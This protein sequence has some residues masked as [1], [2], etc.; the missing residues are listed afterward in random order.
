MIDLNVSINLPVLWGD[1]T[2]EKNKWSAINLFVGPNGTGKTLF[3]EEL[4]KPLKANGYNPRP[5]S[6]ER[7]FGLEKQDYVHFGSRRHGDSGINIA[8]FDR[9]KSEGASFGLVKDAF[10]L[11]KERLDLRITIETIL[12]DIFKKRMRLSEQ[13]GFLKPKMQNLKGGEE[14]VL[15]DSECHGLKELIT[16]LTFIYDKTFDTLI[17]D[18][19]ELHLHPQ[20]Q[21]FLLEEIRKV[22]G[23]PKEDNEKKLFFIISH[24][25]YFLE[26]RTVDDLKNVL[27]FKQENIPTYI[28]T[29]R[30]EDERRLKKFLPRFNTH[31][32]QFFFSPNPVFVEGYTDQQIISLL[33]DK[34]SKNIG[35]S[36]SCVIDVGG[37]DEL[38][39]F[40][41]LCEILNINATFVADLDALFRGRLR[42]TVCSNNKANQYIQDCGIGANLSTEIGTLESKLT[43]LAQAIKN[44]DSDDEKILELKSNLNAIDPTELHKTRFVTLQ[45]V[46]NIKA[47]LLSALQ[48]EESANT[49]F[50]YGKYGELITAFE[51]CNVY[52]LK[53]GTLENYYIKNS[54][55]Y[56][57]K[58]NKDRLFDEERDYILGYENID[59]L[60]K[61]YDD[62]LVTLSKAVPE[63]SIN[64]FDHLKFEV[65]SWIQKVQWCIAR[66][67]ITNI[68]SLKKHALVEYDLY[69]QILDVVDLQVQKE[70]T[71]SCKISL[72]GMNDSNREIT[73]NEKTVAQEFNN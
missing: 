63:F 31:H 44:L 6:A 4:Q 27:V 35:A 57:V 20:F 37:K 24:S 16:L 33:F 62:L 54:N 2:F 50:L 13:G 10:V 65:V 61:Y 3:A 67:D 71:F 19:P 5:L 46:I 26:L 41:R 28:E 49:N 40:Y 17:L 39:V 72:K 32:K 68:E 1:K 60:K 58:N 42:Q 29:L 11:L 30:P 15:Q 9:L 55:I 43:T 21:S 12:S 14:Y 8:E 56:Y 53:K 22:A 59:E 47:K 73:F 38:D 51:K 48:G 34:L 70:K 64:I 18:E 36:G 7:L 52:I 69:N 45:G 25:P 66:G 23:N